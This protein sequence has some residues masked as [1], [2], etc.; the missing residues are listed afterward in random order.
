[1]WHVLECQFENIRQKF[2]VMIWFIVF[3]EKQEETI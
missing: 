2:E 1:M 3:Q